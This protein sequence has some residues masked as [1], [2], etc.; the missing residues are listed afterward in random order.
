[1]LYSL[2]RNL[3]ALFYANLCYS[4]VR[5]LRYFNRVVAGAG[6]EKR[7]GF[8]SRPKQLSISVNSHLGSHHHRYADTPGRAK[9]TRAT[10]LYLPN[11]GGGG[12][13]VT[14]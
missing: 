9:P 2:K 4:I 13:S 10:W 3:A 6:R 8:L 1:M 5:Y 7:N 11:H 12:Q 14:L